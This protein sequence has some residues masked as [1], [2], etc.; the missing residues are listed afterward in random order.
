LEA[1]KDAKESLTV[2]W[3]GKQIHIP[4]ITMP[5]ELLT[6][7]PGTHRIK[8]Q[9]SM[10]P[11]RESDLDTDPWSEPAQNYLHNLLMGDPAD[12]T[13]VDPSFV[14]LMEDLRS[15][16]Q[17][18]PG[19]IT[20]TGV[21]INGNTRRAAL[22]E[23]G[24][25]NIRVGVLPPDAG[26][27]D[28]QSIELSLQLRKD[29]RR[30]YS[31]MNFLLALDEREVARQ[32]P[33]NIQRDFRIT[34]SVFDRSRWILNFVR[35]AIERSKI[36]LEDGTTTGLS[37]VEFE[38]HQGKLEELYR[39]YMALA[40]KSP[41]EANALREQRL[42]A[43]ILDKSKTDLRLIAPDFVRRYMKD[44]L[45]TTAPSSP[46]TIPGT[47]ITVS[48]P[49]P[50]LTALQ[51]MT[52]EVLKARSLTSAKAAATPAEIA[53]AAKTLRDLDESLIKAL[54]NAGKQ[55][56]LIK[57]KLAAADRIS[58]ACDNIDFA[59]E[60]VAGARST[61]NF[62]PEDLDDVLVTLRTKLEKLAMIVVRGTESTAEGIVWLQSAA[63]QST[64]KG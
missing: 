44:K 29:H 28:W 36:R 55:D 38:R 50:E 42:F 45:P 61:S 25:V 64:A 57:R 2:E 27:E 26:Y 9:R 62:D 53:G 3:R 63:S 15:H 56:R 59:I 10:D 17:N 33:A 60:A 34:A 23:L 43:L 41:A 6:Y 54:N 12:P 8:A 47:K 4:V 11:A 16:G 22:K 32:L 31:F 35:D 48:G 37:L 51:Q 5:V 24:V 30:E 13:K 7:N 14:A 52:N 18:D 40:R 46:L 49:D 20:R 39:A 1:L 21:L 58:D 19:I